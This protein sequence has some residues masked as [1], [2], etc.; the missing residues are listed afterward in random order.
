MYLV[1]VYGVG[2]PSD[3][4]E[5]CI[6][7]REHTAVALGMGRHQLLVLV[8]TTGVHVLQLLRCTEEQTAISIGKF[9]F[10]VRSYGCG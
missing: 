6:D 3:V 8:D 2:C 4:V 7:D 5:A 9:N 1:W 10:P